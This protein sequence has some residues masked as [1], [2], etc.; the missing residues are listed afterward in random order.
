MSSCVVRWGLT[1]S[2]MVALS[3]CASERHRQALYEQAHRHV[4]AQPIEKVWPQVVSLVAASGY[5]PRKGGDAFILVSEWRNDTM[6]SRVVSSSS[7]IYA[8]GYRV[9][10]NSCFV[11]IFR[12]SI[13]TGDKGAMSARENSLASSITV[14]GA[15]DASPFAEDPIKLNQFLGTSA[16]HTPLT[17]AP[18]QMTRSFSRDGELEWKLLQYLDEAKAQAIEA[19]ITE[20]E[21]Q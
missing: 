3:G 17:R 13:F 7:R 5:P 4:Y 2:V 15:G 21:K 19:R 12:Q 10:S 14:G 11:R 18:A 6:D 9:D 20:L 16:D 1:L 8:E